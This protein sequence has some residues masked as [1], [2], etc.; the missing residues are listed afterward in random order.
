MKPS[1]LLGTP[2]SG[3]SVNWNCRTVRDDPSRASVTYNP[4]QTKIQAL[5]LKLFS[6]N[7]RNSYKHSNLEF[8]QDILGHVILGDWVDYEALIPD[9]TVRWPILMAFLL[10]NNIGLV[11]VREQGYIKRKSIV[12]TLPIS[13]NLVNITMMVE[14]CSQS[15][16]QKSSVVSGRGP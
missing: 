3:Q 13:F 7:Q 4:Q 5:K 1:P 10:Q 16:R 14:L 8:P 6:L 2:C 12:R 9:G 15:I 11:C